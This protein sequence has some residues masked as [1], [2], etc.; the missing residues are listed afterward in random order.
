MRNSWTVILGIAVASVSAGALPDSS[1]KPDFSGAAGLALKQSAA[2]ARNGLC[3]YLS[4]AESRDLAQL[5]AGCRLD[6]Q[7]VVPDRERAGRLRDELQSNALADRLSVTWRRTS[8]LPYLDNLVNLIVAPNW[9]QGESKGL[10]LAELVRVLAP[11]GVAVVGADT[12]LDPAALLAEAR[13]LELAQAEP[14]ARPGA[15]IGIVKKINPAFGEWTQYAGGGGQTMVSTD[16]AVAPGKEVRWVNLPTWSSGG[17]RNDVLAGGR[18]FH[19]ENEWSGGKSR[20]WVMVARDAFNGCELWREKTGIDSAAHFK[21]PDRS[22]CA[23]DKRVYYNDGSELIARDAATGKLLMKY[24]R[25]SGSVISA[26]DWLITQGAVIVKETGKTVMELNNTPFHSSPVAL[27]GVVYV[28]KGDSASGDGVEAFRMTDGKSLWKTGLKDL[29]ARKDKTIARLMARG[30]NV[31]VAVGLNVTALDRGNGSV[32]WS[33]SPT[34]SISTVEIAVLPLADQV[35]LSFKVRTDAKGNSVLGQIFLDSATGKVVKNFRA[36]AGIA[37]RCWSMRATDRFLLGGDALFIDHKSSE[38]LGRTLGGIRPGCGVGKSVAYGLEYMGPHGCSCSVSL[39]GAVATSC[40]SVM[41]KGVVSPQLIEGA[42]AVT[43]AAAAAG[44]WPVYR[45]DVQRSGACA[46]ELPAQLKKLWSVK[47][48]S[49]P[50]PQVTGAGGL[51]FAADPERHR[52]VALALASGKEQWSFATEGRVSVAPTYYKGLC[53][54]GDHAGWVYCLEAASGKLVWQLQAA[55]EQKLMSAFNRFESAWPVK[56]G[57]LVVKDRACF[58]AGRCGIMDGG[59]YFYSVEPLTGKVLA[60][61]NYHDTRPTDLLVSDG[62]TVMLPLSREVLEGQQPSSYNPDGDDPGKTA[63]TTTV[64]AVTRLRA[65][66][67][68]YYQHAILDILGS[69][70]P[71]QTASRKK[72]LTAGKYNGDL[73]VFDKDRTVMNGRNRGFWADDLKTSAAD[74]AGIEFIVCKGASSWVKKDTA[75]QMQALLLAGARVYGAGIPQARDGQD[76]PALW[77]LSSEDGRQLQKLP[78]DGAPNIDGLSAL[79]GKLLL[80]TLDGQLQCFDAP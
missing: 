25:S 40:G 70:E 60:R 61:M 9:G 49:D 12:G 44:D 54:F 45:A 42:R 68:T 4:P 56:S 21:A 29:A 38:F 73:I 13:K 62:R 23:D 36:T 31:Y 41:P 30:E 59:I 24:G 79:G 46:G 27:D 74:G 19:E 1:D 8:H 33:Y 22:L 18:N 58:I 75:Q 66:G 80:T 51:L 52:V 7:G 17:Y 67:G 10:A 78:L 6:V 64:A 35:S 15:W 39:R 26:G 71:V 16:T 50:L 76:K 37:A 55:P 63:T 48:G 2:A 69:L 28:L 57:V 5:A 72:V 65:G 34:N 14:L 47:L 20:Q 77:I 43:G 3:L 11:G 53:L 32:R